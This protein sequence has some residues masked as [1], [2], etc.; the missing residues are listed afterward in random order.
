MMSLAPA[1]W[2]SSASLLIALMVQPSQAAIAAESAN[3]DSESPDR[4]HSLIKDILG[5]SGSVRGAFFSKDLSFS[6]NTGYAVGSIWATAKPQSVFGINSYFDARV[7]GQDLTRSSSLRW[8]LREG[9]LQT[10]V[11]PL[12]L[13][14]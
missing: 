1:T 4:E 11:G 6:G 8:E 10:S 5:I 3:G 7:Q 12:D 13:K 2:R 9:Y 14:A